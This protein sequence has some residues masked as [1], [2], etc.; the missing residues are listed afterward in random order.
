VRA[1]RAAAWQESAKPSAGGSRLAARAVDSRSAPET[2]EVAV[3]DKI[4]SR[5]TLA[6]RPQ[7]TMVCPTAVPLKVEQIQLV[8]VEACFHL[9][10]R[11]FKHL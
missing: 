6:G 4:P 7:K 2:S 10:V 9:D 8:R 1:N 5:K 11:P 3:C